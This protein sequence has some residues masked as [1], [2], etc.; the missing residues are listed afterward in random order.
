MLGLAD[1]NQLVG[2]LY[3]DMA[4]F[5]ALQPHFGCILAKMHCDY[6]KTP[7]YLSL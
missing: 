2:G 1:R 6:L 3:D 7:R 4:P 5:V